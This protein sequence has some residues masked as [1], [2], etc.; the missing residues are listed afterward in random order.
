MIAQVDKPYIKKRPLKLWPRLVAYFLFEGRPLTTRGQWINPFL[1]FLYGVIKR[2]PGLK[3]VR[4]PV[5]IL[6]TGRSGTT[7]L[8]VVMS[9]HRDVGFLNEPKALWHS[10]IGGEDLIGSY[11]RG[12]AAY[13]LK[14]DDVTGLPALNIKKLFAAYLRLGCSSRVL[15]KY[16]ELVFRL[17]MVLQAFPDAKFLFL[18]RDGWE[19]CASINRWSERLGETKNGEKHDWWGVNDRKWHLLLDQ[20]VQEHEDLAKH[21]DDLRVLDDHRLRAVVEWVV[22]MREGLSVQAKYPSQ[23]LTVR[24]EKLAAA[25]RQVLDELQS[26]CGLENDEVM[27]AYGAEVLKV[28][29]SHPKFD[30]PEWLAPAFRKTMADLGYV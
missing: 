30:L 10:A 23:V 14:K 26:F 1:F 19:T 20:L 15:D 6:G 12:P 2:L 9:M 5:F 22:T 17:P 13:R 3:A 28:P 4:Q 16:P 11:S 27:K 24:Y 8:G 25:P 29:E 18:V 7:I 21:M